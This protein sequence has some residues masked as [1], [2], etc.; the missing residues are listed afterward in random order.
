MLTGDDRDVGCWLWWL[1]AWVASALKRI[2]LV[3]RGSVS[4]MDYKMDFK[5]GMN[6]LFDS[7]GRK[8]YV[9]R[10]F[11]TYLLDPK[12]NRSSAGR[13]DVATD[14]DNNS[15]SN[16]NNAKNGIH[17]RSKFDDIKRELDKCCQ[18]FPD[19]RLYVTGYV[20]RVFDCELAFSPVVAFPFEALCCVDL[21]S[22]HVL[23]S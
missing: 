16:N 13:G 6:K 19:H 21:K 8:V 5:I 14:D 11:S 15:N 1:I 7:T 18:Q 23:L 2:T 20:C 3:F 4:A 17:N 22:R 12:H 9:H 10:G